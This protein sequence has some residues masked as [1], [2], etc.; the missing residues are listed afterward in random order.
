MPSAGELVGFPWTVPL[1]LDAGLSPPG[2][3]RGK[4]GGGWQWWRGKEVLPGLQGPLGSGHEDV[5]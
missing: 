4:V 2:A 3:T 5:I 1:V